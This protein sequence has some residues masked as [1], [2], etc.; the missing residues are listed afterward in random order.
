MPI[1]E[2]ARHERF[3]QLVA[4]GKCS[5]MEAF[6]QAGYADERATRVQELS[7][8]ESEVANVEHKFLVRN[9]LFY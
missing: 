9:D 5:D 8:Y 6:R 4:S 2:D 1:L 7:H 3:A